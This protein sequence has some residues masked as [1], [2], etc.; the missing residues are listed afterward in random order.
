MN[1]IETPEQPAIEHN[2]L[3]YDLIMSGEQY[4]ESSFVEGDVA[5]YGYTISGLGNTLYV[6]GVEHVFDPESPSF[7]DIEEAFA[8]ANPDLVLVEGIYNLEGRDPRVF[9]YLNSL[10]IEEAKARGEAMFVLKLA[11]DQIAQGKDIDMESPE[12]NLREEVHHIE[13]QGFDQQDIFNYYYFRDVE[14]FYRESTD[15]AAMEMELYVRPSIERFR[16]ESGWDDLDLQRYESN[17]KEAV[18]EYTEDD[19]K[20]LIDPI[21]WPDKGF[22]VTN[23]IAAASSNFRDRNILDR[24]AKGMEHHKRVLIVYGTTHAVVLEP[25]LKALMEDLPA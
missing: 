14:Q 5:T 13:D 3:P 16:E 7:L 10:S 18:A 24:I 22:D 2:E 12:P 23:Q 1:G 8:N 25:A 6:S 9:A 21:P 17:A 11:S 20:G 4:V 19:L 15:H